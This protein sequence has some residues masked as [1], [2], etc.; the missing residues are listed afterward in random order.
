GPR[1][2]QN[3]MPR[4]WLVPDYGPLLTDGQSLVWEL[5]GGHVKAMTEETFLGE[6]VVR[7]NTGKVSSTAQRWADNM[8]AK[9]DE[10]SAKEPIFGQLRNCMD[11]AVA[12]ALIFKENLPFKSGC[13]LGV[14]VNANQLP[15]EEMLAPK[16]IDTQASFVKKGNNWVISASGGVQIQ[17]WAVVTKVE[18]NER[19]VSARGSH[20]PE[21]LKK[22]WWD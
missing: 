4:W 10:L 8:T 5:P 20:E 3:M 13:D 19:V 14:L 11:L 12:A 2:M 21:N 1:G 17:P 16:R 6:G 9:Y 7:S 22:W 15:A 18:K